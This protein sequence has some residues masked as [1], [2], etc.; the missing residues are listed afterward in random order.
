M[1][2]ALLALKKSNRYILAALS[3]TIA[4]PA[5]Y[6]H[7]FLPDEHDVKGIFDIFVSSAH[8]GMR[9]PNEDIY[10]YTLKEVDKFAKEVSTNVMLYQE[11]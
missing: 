3:N 5:S 10:L 2:P 7:K 6:D 11:E 4:F 9:K 8:V 1:H